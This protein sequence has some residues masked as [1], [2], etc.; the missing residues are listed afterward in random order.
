MPLL[1]QSLTKYKLQIVGFMQTILMQLTNTILNYV[2]SL[3]AEIS[4]DIL[5]I[6]PQQIQNLNVTVPLQSNNNNVLNFSSNNTTSHNATSVGGSS[7]QMNGNSNNEDIS[8][9]TQYVL[10]IQL[11]YRSYFQFLLN[12]TNNDVMEIFLNQTSN[13][14]YKIYF[15]L[16]QGV[17][18]GTPEI[19]KACLQVL[20]KLISFF[21]ES[22]FFSAK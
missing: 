2:N 14:I 17:Q 4:S 1:N 6:S 18:I 3:P 21:G 8:P 10:D 11:L 15:T 5:K 22:H 9:D 16:L 7:V 12:I 20:K 13:D 19:S